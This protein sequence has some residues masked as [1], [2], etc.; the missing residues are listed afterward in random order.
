MGR[1]AYAFVIGLVGAGIVHI[2]ILLLLPAYS[3]R[4]PWTR[5]VALSDLYER[6]QVTGGSDP[7]IRPADP[8]FDAVA[9]RFDLDDGM[10]RLQAPGQ[11][12][13][14]SLSVY[15]RNG[16]NIY[17][18]TDRTANDRTLDVVVLTGL[19]MIEMRR[20]LLPGLENAIFVE[21]EVEEGIV[22]VRSFRA[23]PTWTGTISDYLD[24]LSCRP[25]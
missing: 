9:C 22:L 7:L 3:P 13:Y 18:F 25:I 1:F 20:G 19:Q 17:S 4:D 6:T 12:P 5:L 10:L 15:D 23:D 21:T 2:A 24:G 11:V 16:E 8:F 14:W